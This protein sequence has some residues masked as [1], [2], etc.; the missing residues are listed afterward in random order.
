MR[1]RNIALIGFRAT[2]KSSVGEIL[3]HTLRREFIDMDRRLITEAGRDIAEWVEQEGWGSFRK[4]E[5]ALL[6]I[7]RMQKELVV[8]TGGGIILDPEN[9]RA[10]SEEFF[11]VWLR[12]SPQT[13]HE[14]LR[15]D[16]ESPRT[17]P[18]LLPLPVREEIERVLAERVPLYSHVAHLQIDTEGKQTFRLAEEIACIFDRGR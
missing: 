8:A 14:R 16:P 6:G 18:A 9:R 17:R 10:L 1:E 3:A 7:V 5:S 15:L 11:T 13:I 2:G 12:A 4:A